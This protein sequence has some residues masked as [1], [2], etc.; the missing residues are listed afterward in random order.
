MSYVRKDIPDVLFIHHYFVLPTYY[1][2]LYMAA[3][4]ILLMVI[5]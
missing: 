5:D 1:D 3:T 4:T 2:L